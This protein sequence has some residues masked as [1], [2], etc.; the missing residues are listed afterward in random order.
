ML[1]IGVGRVIFLLFNLLKLN[2]MNLE[3]HKIKKMWASYRYDENYTAVFTTEG[4]TYLCKEIQYRVTDVLLI[5]VR[6]Y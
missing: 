3:Y 5:D 1:L 6:D 2:K 4:K